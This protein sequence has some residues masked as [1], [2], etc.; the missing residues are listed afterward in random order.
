M[1][2][3]TLLMSL[4]GTQP[5]SVL[6]CLGGGAFESHDQRQEEE[7]CLSH[8]QLPLQLGPLPCVPRAY[9]NWVRAARTTV[10]RRQCT[11]GYSRLQKREV[12][13]SRHSATAQAHR[14][15]CELSGPQISDSTRNEP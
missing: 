7:T 5:N 8:K 14:R 1:V 11:Q 15:Y 10:P 4:N 12:T 6:L 13:D 3:T 9:I 2:T